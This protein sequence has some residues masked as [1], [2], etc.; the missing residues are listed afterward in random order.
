MKK[1]DFPAALNIASLPE[2]QRWQP[3][4]VRSRRSGDVERNWHSTRIKAGFV[5]QPPFS[6]A[7]WLTLTSPTVQLHRGLAPISLCNSKSL[8]CLHLSHWVKLCKA[9]IWIPGTTTLPK[10]CTASTVPQMDRH[11]ARCSGEMRAWKNP[12]NDERWQRS[13]QP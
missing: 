2:H 6:P 13:L 4:A 12:G 5:A 9:S 3:R 7:G 10:G 1:A 11:P 8:H